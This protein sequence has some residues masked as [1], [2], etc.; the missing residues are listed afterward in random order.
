MSLIFEKRVLFCL[1]I[2][3]FFYKR[4]S[5]FSIFNILKKATFIGPSPLQESQ[6]FVEKGSLL[7]HQKSAF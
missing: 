5:I 6:H 2:R 3:F 7:G 1:N 4:V